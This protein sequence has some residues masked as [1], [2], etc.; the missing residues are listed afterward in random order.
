MYAPVQM[1]LT[2]LQP[3]ELQAPGGSPQQVRPRQGPSE[4]FPF[5]LVQS[6]QKGDLFAV[7]VFPASK[8]PKVTPVGDPD[9]GPDVP[10]LKAST[11]LA[12]PHQATPS[13]QLLGIGTHVS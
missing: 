8:D 4:H 5:S 1:P 11:P 12:F 9:A 6:P 7:H 3:P 10:E 13:L 2:P